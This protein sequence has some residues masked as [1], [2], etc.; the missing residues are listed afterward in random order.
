[1]NATVVKK[2]H[3]T[4][5]DVVIG[6]N[7]LDIYLLPGKC[8][9]FL[10]PKDIIDYF[11]PLVI[12]PNMVITVTG[13][14]PRFTCVSVKINNSFDQSY[15]NNFTITSKGNIVPAVYGKTWCNLWQKDDGSSETLVNNTIN[16]IISSLY[17]N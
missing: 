3:V 8:W 17:S 1:M 12:K 9:S 15:P 10:I 14:N 11:N 6:W 2:E 4:E 5:G 16:Y 7:D 13:P